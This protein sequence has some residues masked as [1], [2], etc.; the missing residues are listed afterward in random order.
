MTKEI[1]KAFI[2]Q[3]IQDKFGLRELEPEKFS[4]LESVMPIY[5]IEQHLKTWESR[6]LDLTV[7]ATG[8]KTIRIIPDM[9]RWLLQSYTMVF[10]S[11]AFTVAGGYILRSLRRDGTD[12]SYLD[13]K[14]AQSVSYLTMLPTPVVLEPGDAFMVNID[15]YTS[16]GTLRIHYDYQRETLR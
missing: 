11:G 9:E 16:S 7:A 14:A 5:N 15:G 12:M 2:L 6:W 10:I 8:G 13:L 3:Q 4:F 1:T